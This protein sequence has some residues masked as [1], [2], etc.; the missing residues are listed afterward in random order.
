MIDNVFGGSGGSSQMKVHREVDFRGEV[1]TETEED[2][3]PEES[4]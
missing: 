3:A 4:K 2:D 1:R